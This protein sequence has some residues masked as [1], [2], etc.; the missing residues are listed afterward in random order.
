MLHVGSA[1]GLLIYFW[2]TWIDLIKAFFVSLARMIRLRRWSVQTPDEH[3]AW[4][5]V[6]TSIPTGNRGVLLEQPERL[7]TAQRLIAE[8]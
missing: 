8:C 7:G 2:R 3:L 5:I 6:I 4:L 1:V